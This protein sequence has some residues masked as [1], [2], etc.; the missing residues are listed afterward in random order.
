M[1]Q[2]RAVRNFGSAD[3]T[4]GKMLRKQIDSYKDSLSSSSSGSVASMI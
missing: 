4:F 2:D 3:A 1:F